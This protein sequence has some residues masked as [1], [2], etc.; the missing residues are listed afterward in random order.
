MLPSMIL[1]PIVENAIKHGLTPKPSG[2]T[3][4]LRTWTD[5]DDIKISI[6]DD[7]VGFH[8]DSVDESK[9]VGLQNVRFRLRHMMDGDLRIESDPGCGTTVTII[10]PQ[11][12][13][14]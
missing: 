1:Q 5:G 4:T 9:S 8:V 14:K 11:H 2:G 13:Q 6:Q 7:G 12:G 3:I 10:L